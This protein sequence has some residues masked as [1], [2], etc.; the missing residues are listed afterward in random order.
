MPVILLPK[1]WRK[2]VQKWGVNLRILALKDG[3]TSRTTN[4]A[5]TV[6]IRIYYS[7][8]AKNSGTL[9]WPKYLCTY[10]AD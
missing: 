3:T 8:E 10:C 4:K 1:R 2:L 7:H 9:S 5:C 6:G